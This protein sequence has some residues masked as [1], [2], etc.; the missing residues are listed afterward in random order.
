MPLRETRPSWFTPP[1]R[2]A[3]PGQY[4]GTRQAHPGDRFTIPGFDA[5]SFLNDASTATPSEVTP[6]GHFL[7]RLPGPHLTHLVRRFPEAHHD[8]LPAYLP[9]ST[10]VTHVAGEV[11]E[12]AVAGLRGR[13]GL[14]QPL[15]PNRETNVSRPALA[16]VSSFCRARR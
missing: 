1:P 11:D 12:L 9:P 4:S 5:T 16:S 8:G 2:R 13:E 6:A 15:R 7:V 10:F 3:P 14:T